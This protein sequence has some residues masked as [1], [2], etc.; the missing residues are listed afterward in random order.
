MCSMSGD[1]RFLLSY[2]L[3]SFGHVQNLGQT[4]PDEDVRRMIKMPVDESYLCVGM[5]FVLCPRAFGIL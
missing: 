5:R 2:Q 1:I 4:P 3:T